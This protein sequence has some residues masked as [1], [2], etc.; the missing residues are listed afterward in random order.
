MANLYPA[1]L[2]C[3]M[4]NQ[5]IY[6]PEL[7]NRHFPLKVHERMLM[8]GLFLDPAT[9]ARK[10]TQVALRIILSFVFQSC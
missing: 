7:L 9:K 1:T 3:L 4:H 5:E 10:I 8:V 2:S 6:R